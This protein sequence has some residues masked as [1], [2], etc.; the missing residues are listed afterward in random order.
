MDASVCSTYSGET[1]WIYSYKI[2]IFFF[3]C[4]LLIFLNNVFH[5]NPTKQQTDED[6]WGNLHNAIPLSCIG[7]LY[8]TRLLT[9]SVMQYI[10]YRLLWCKI[11][12]FHCYLIFFIHLQAAVGF[13]SPPQQS[14]SS[15]GRIYIPQHLQKHPLSIITQWVFLCLY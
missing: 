12:T 4:K 6:I 5:F 11:Q 8:W 7:C 3:A 14:I 1:S 10:N 15:T 9:S 2:E 13:S